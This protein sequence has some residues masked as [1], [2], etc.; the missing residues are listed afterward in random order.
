MEEIGWAKI[1][2][3]RI[4]MIEFATT[5]MQS[6]YNNLPLLLWDWPFWRRPKKEILESNKIKKREK[7]SKLKQ[8]KN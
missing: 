4:I 3:L 7:F 1:K 2:K 8:K 5:K 6:L